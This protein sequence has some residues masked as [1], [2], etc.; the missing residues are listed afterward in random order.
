MKTAKEMLEVGCL[1]EFENGDTALC[2]PY[3]D[4]V[5][6]K[7]KIVFDFCDKGRCLL[8][9]DFDEDLNFIENKLRFNAKKIYGFSKFAYCTTGKDVE[10]RKVIWERKPKLKIGDRIYVKSI[11]KSILLPETR[12]YCKILD[13]C[14]FDKK[15]LFKFYMN[16]TGKVIG[17][18]KNKIYIKFDLD[19]LDFVDSLFCGIPFD[20]D[21][22]ISIERIKL[23]EE[24]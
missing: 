7:N 22:L 3:F 2:M 18:D 4:G 9:D 8:L 20:V 19:L 5:S 10:D 23:N 6:K 17:V 15:D 13:I 16:Q 21:D 1:V 14:M 24:K 11:E 12:R